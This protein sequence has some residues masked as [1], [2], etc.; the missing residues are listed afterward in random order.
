MLILIFDGKSE[1]Y[2]LE[3]IINKWYSAKV[4]L[5]NKEPHNIWEV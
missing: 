1:Y 2:I 4:K 3:Q 5:Y